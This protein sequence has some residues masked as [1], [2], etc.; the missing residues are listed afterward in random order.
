MDRECKMNPKPI[1]VT[2]A[3][4]SGT[5]WVGKMISASRDVGYIHEPFNLAHRPGICRAEFPY[6]FTYIT[7][8]HEAVFRKQLSETIS[9]H[10]HL[11]GETKAIRCPKDALRMLRDYMRFSWCRV[12]RVRPL[13]KDPIGIFSAEW[14]AKAFDMDVVIL[15]RHPAA[16][17]SSLKRLNYRHPFSHFLQQPLLMSDH[18]HSFSAE[19]ERFAV[20]EHDVIDQAI[21]LYKLIYSVVSTYK[22]KHENWVF[23]RHEDLSRDPVVGFQDLFK[24]LNVKFTP[25]IHK[26]IQEHSHSTNPKEA[27]QGVS[28]LKLNSKLNICNWRRRLT[29]AEI[30]RVRNGVEAI[31]AGFYSDSDW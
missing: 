21:L 13:L 18:L 1:L 8:E 29:A 2:G 16:F 11:I 15:V 3:H 27:P 17:A 19:I 28:S 30:E 24:V 20:E 26:V 12:R 6:W 23:V 7:D 22:N 5:T 25:R 14:L 31:S 4:R 10:Y 9:F